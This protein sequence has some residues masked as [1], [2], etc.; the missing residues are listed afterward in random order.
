M[1][2]TKFIAII[3]IIFVILLVLLICF[4]LLKLYRVR[5]ENK[6]IIDTDINNYIQYNI[7]NNINII[8]IEKLKSK[9][10]ITSVF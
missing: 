5:E 4:L 8:N 2:V 10:I 3:L 7:D 1:N 9:K 6:D